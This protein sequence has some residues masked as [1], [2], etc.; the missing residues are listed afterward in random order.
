[1]VTLKKIYT[2]LLVLVGVF[3]IFST[4]NAQTN[5]LLYGSGST[6]PGGY[7]AS[8]D[9]FDSS[10]TL[11][12][13]SDCPTSGN[14]ITM[15]VGRGNA[16]QY[17]WSASYIYNTSV[18]PARW[19]SH[20]LTGTDGGGGWLIGTGSKTITTPFTATAS[21]PL[22]LVGY[23]CSHVSSVWRC[24]CANASC[25]SKHWQLQAYKGNSGG[26]T[27][28][29]GTGGTT[30]GG[31]GALIQGAFCGKNTMYNWLSASKAG[32]FID[33]GNPIQNSGVVRSWVVN[34]NSDSSM[35]VPRPSNV[36]IALAGWVP[37]LM[38]YTYTQAANNDP[39][40]REQW[41]NIGEILQQSGN[42]NAIIYSSETETSRK[43]W[44]P[45]AGD[46]AGGENS[47]WKK[48]WRNMVNAVRSEAPNVQF[49]FTPYTG[50]QAGPHNGYMNMEDWYVSGT[51]NLGK[52]YMD[53]WGF[54]LYLHTHG[55]N[56]Y[57]PSCVPTRTD[58]EEHMAK[59]R[60]DPNVPWSVAQQIN[61]ARSKGIKLYNSEL[62]IMVDRFENQHAG[63]EAVAIDVL[64][65]FV[66]DTRAD[67]YANVWFN[68]DYPEG[69]SKLDGSS[70]SG[71]RASERVRQL[72][73]Y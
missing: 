73:G 34:A 6:P 50:W 38:D 48:A 28:G 24:G 22:Y 33:S 11:L 71:P 64:K 13:K 7:G 21:N 3:G 56:C 72:F 30:G 59:V 44:H 55:S 18:T 40:W 41:V 35:N 68:C 46:M 45:K 12:V 66:N 15:T 23:V 37:V 53:M 63:D 36:R 19:D 58:F 51:D 69:N 57:Y 47:N 25:T 17:I 70:G 1:M 2:F 52:P 61:F 27:G 29:S 4:A 8:W 31:G 49:A 67:V 39:N 10:R 43:R 54:T 60:M 42:G 26:T 16:A 20:T 9:V 14:A 5:C 32:L 62:G 65:K